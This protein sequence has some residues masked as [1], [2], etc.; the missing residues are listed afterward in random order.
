MEI[1]SQIA[2]KIAP[3]RHFFPLKVVPLIE[4]L[5]YSTSLGFAW[6]TL[7]SAKKEFRVRIRILLENSNPR[8][9]ACQEDALPF[10]SSGKPNGYTIREGCNPFFF[11]KLKVPGGRVR[12]RRNAH[13]TVSEGL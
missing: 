4:V 6:G 10:G 8:T 12:R 9:S 3:L 11:V 2:W 7:S 13:L 1:S 5:L